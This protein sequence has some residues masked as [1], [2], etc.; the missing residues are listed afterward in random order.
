MRDADGR[1]AEGEGTLPEHYHCHRLPVLAAADGTV[2]A[3]ESGLPDN[4]VGALDLDHN[5]GNHV[6]VQ[7]GAGLYSLSAHLARG[8]V[9]VQKGQ[10][11]RRGE[12]IG[13]CGSSGRSPRPHLH[14]HLQGT[15]AL[16]AATI[17]CR[18]ADIVVGDGE[19]RLS[20]SMAPSLGDAVESLSPGG[21]LASWLALE[22]G[23]EWTFRHGGVVERLAADV[24]LYGRH[25]VRSRDLPA[26][27]F[28]GRSDTVFTAYDVVGAPG[29]VLHLLR[30]ALPRV[31]L[32]A[33][34]PSA[35]RITCPRVPSGPGSGGVL[36]DLVSPFLPLDG[37]E[38]DFGLRRDGALLVVEGASRRRDRRG[39]PIVRTRASLAKGVG[40][41]RV[42]V[43]VRGRTRAA[44]RVL[45][46]RVSDSSD[47]G[48]YG[49]MSTKHW[50]SLLLLGVALG[51]GVAEAGAESTSDLFQRSYDAEAAGKAGDALAAIDALP[52]PLHDA[53][54]AQLR[55]GW[56]LY[57]LG[58][59]PEAIDAY[60]RAAA[61]E[62][63]SVEAR[64]GALLP[65][66]AARR[67]ADAET[68]A[69]DALRI[70]PGNY[71]A[72]LRMAFALYNL[73]RYP[74]SAALYR[75]LVDAYPSDVEV[76]SGLGWALL[77]GGKVAEA[78]LAF[79]A[80]LDVA[81]RNTLAADGLKAA[82]AAR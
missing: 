51:C 52:A 50:V 81:P 71:L 47:Q 38:M 37:I 77:K 67:W 22:P 18:F 27:L 59:S 63:R 72:T 79:R 48:G 44:E 12:V 73:G 7:H 69:R 76:R 14:F 62:P 32:A 35:G 21:D 70:D 20:A 64:V 3:V 41:V 4:P 34:P 68:T 24:D 25:L 80:V 75:K 57:K 54:V 16:G 2:I 28:Y 8:S 36:L 40:P 1:L 9:K 61:L 39:A 56:L 45:S 33:L 15:P 58:K 19:A 78:A 26:T 23:D 11:V 46:S 49:K 10:I 13:L 6:I 66:M 42:E 74:E 5:W 82:G 60:A 17:P 30:A 65:Q 31:P 53:Y 55:R 43:S 29:S